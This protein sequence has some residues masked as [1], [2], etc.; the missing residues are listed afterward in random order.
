MAS[1][2]AIKTAWETF[3]N[4]PSTFGPDGALEPMRAA[5]DAAA[6]VDGDGHLQREGAD[7]LETLSARCGEL[8][9]RCAEAYQAVGML[10]EA[11]D[12]NDDENIIRLQDVLA[13]GKTTD[14][15][16][17]LPFPLL[18]PPK[19]A[20]YDAAVE[21]IERYSFPAANGHSKC[22]SNEHFSALLA[23]KDSTNEK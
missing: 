2:K 16:E 4:T 22:V 15:K 20:A 19:L 3:Q 10:A 9:T 8:E 23:C 18:T 12:A 17:L 21:K 14:G 11:L 13:Y 6:A 5:L 1:E 7:A